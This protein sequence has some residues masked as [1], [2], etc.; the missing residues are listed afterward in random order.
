MAKKG[1]QR[2]A[3]VNNKMCGFMAYLELIS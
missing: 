2:L 1:S 3:F